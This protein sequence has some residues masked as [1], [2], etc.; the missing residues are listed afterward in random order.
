MNHGSQSNLRRARRTRKS[1]A[2]FW[3]TETESEFH[4]GWLL[5][6]SDNGFAF[7]WRG[8]GPPRPR[9]ELEMQFEGEYAPDGGCHATVRR[10]TC[11]HSD[12]HI[13]AGELVVDGPV[14]A[15]VLP[16]VSRPTR[17]VPRASAA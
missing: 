9:D 1:S 12:L 8:E 3:K 15:R 14:V 4:M 5:E 13:I 7:A 16:I 10:V 11:V 6:A 2:V 17:A